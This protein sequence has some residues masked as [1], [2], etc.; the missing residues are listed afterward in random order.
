[1]GR[2]WRL[3]LSPQTRCPGITCS[4]L[5]WDSCVTK[6]LLHT[7][8]S[9][10][11][12]SMAHFLITHPTKCNLCL[13]ALLIL[14]TNLTWYLNHQDHWSKHK[15]APDSLQ[16]LALLLSPLSHPETQ[17]QTLTPR[18]QARMVNVRPPDS[19]SRQTL[20][21]LNPPSPVHPRSPP[22]RCVLAP[23]GRHVARSL[24]ELRL[25]VDGAGQP[26]PP[27]AQRVCHDPSWL[28]LQG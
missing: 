14:L 9:L 10:N 28:R 12:D 4:H 23:V 27:W 22:P 1:M 11:L 16:A 7:L 6:S 26:E 15:V 8:P 3:R 25:T 24:S 18:S 13:K 20:C 19:S 2:G 21:F 5:S 17:S